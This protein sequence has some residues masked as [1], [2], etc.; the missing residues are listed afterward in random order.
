VATNWRVFRCIRCGRNGIET[1]SVII[2]NWGFDQ[3]GCLWFS[4]WCTRCGFNFTITH[5]REEQE[6]DI[7]EMFH[8]WCKEAGGEP[9]DFK[10]WEWEV[11]EDGEDTA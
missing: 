5:S 2:R 6:S 9:T 8:A 10:L 3:D 1:P 11:K 4:G 7:R